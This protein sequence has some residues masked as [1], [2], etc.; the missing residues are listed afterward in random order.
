MVGGGEFHSSLESVS[1]TAARSF[2]PVFSGLWGIFNIYL[3]FSVSA[4]G[5]SSLWLCQE[6]VDISEGW[7]RDVCFIFARERLAL[8]FTGEATALSRSPL[9]L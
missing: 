8:K 6:P 2:S 1:G 5:E 9:L 4:G 3:V 7:R